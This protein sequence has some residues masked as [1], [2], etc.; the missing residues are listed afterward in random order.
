MATK[1]MRSIVD[2][3]TAPRQALEGE[4]SAKRPNHFERRT[5]AIAQANETEASVQV[6]V[7][8]SRCR[9]WAGNARAYEE[10][11]YER[12]AGLINA[13]IA[14]GKQEIPAIGRR[15]RDDPEH[16]FEIIAGARRHW[17]V[18]WL[19]NNGYPDFRYFVEIRDIDTDEEAFRIADIENRD[20]EDVSAYERAVEYASALTNYYEGDRERMAR[21]LEIGKATLSRYIMLAELPDEVVGAFPDRLSVSLS[22]AQA[23][24]P[25]L[26]DEKKRELVLNKAKELREVRRQAQQEG[27]QGLSARE[28]V[29]ELEESG[30]TSARRRRTRILPEL[31]ASN[32]EV[33]IKVESQSGKGYRLF[34]P[35]RKPAKDEFINSCKALYERLYEQGG[36]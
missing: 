30:K 1:K 20:R 9:I 18:S 2:E 10:L 34:V 15:I 23:L 25:L 13:L 7:D 27:R 26:K 36:Q 29:R 22:Q 16:D 8:P 12:C 17:S 3:I 14:Q 19:R 21:R 33:V 24:N 32:G 11:N 35:K 5:R 4:P 31:R 6:R 28:V